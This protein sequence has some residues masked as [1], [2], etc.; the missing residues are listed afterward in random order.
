VDLIFL[1]A[2]P[3]QAAAAHLQAVARVSRLLRQGG[4]ARALRSARSQEELVAVLQDAE[5]A[6]VSG[7]P[8]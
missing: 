5:T 7:V 2:S 3:T 4:L 1:V 6:A 8:S